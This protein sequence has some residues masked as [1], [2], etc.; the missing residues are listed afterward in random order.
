MSFVLRQT[1]T[2]R[3]NEKTSHPNLRY[4]KNLQTIEE[5]DSER[6]ARVCALGMPKH[7]SNFPRHNGNNYEDKAA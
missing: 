1:I 3:D 2:N 7:R 4:V 6:G 5:R